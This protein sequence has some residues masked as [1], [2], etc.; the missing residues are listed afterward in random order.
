M[1]L[2][3]LLGSVFLQ[4]GCSAEAEQVFG[5]AM[6]AHPESLPAL[7]GRAA[8]LQSLARHSE[9][10]E[11]LDRAVENHPESATAWYNRGV[12]RMSTGQ[13][14][15]AEADFTGALALQPNSAKLLESRGAA[16]AFQGAQSANGAM[17]D[18]KSALGLDPRNPDSW[19]MLGRCF[20][21][22]GQ[23]GEAAACWRRALEIAPQHLQSLLDRGFLLSAQQQH[24]DALADFDRVISLWR[25][26]PAAWQGR[27]IAL[28]SLNHQQPAIDS[29]SE[30]LRISPSDTLSLFNRAVM[31]TAAKH[32]VDAAT[33]LEALLRLNP[34]YPLARGLL[35][36]ARLQLCDWRDL[37]QQ[38]RAIAEGLQRGFRVIHP[39]AHLLI[40]DSPAGQLA[41][42][43]LQ[44][45][46]AHP[47]A[48]APLYRG[49]KY[50]HDKIRIAYVSGD[51]FE[52]AVP[53][54]IVGVLEHHDRSRFEITAISYGSNDHSNMRRRLEAA[55]DRFVDVPDR[56]DSAIARRMREMEFDIAIDLKGHTGRARPG[57]F[58]SRPAPVQVNYLGYPGTMGAPYFD[59]LI[60]DRILIPP[61]HRPFYS[62]NIVYLPDCYQANDRARVIA[63]EPVSRATAG[64]PENAFVFC[65]F[66]GNQKILPD[67]F[68]MWMRI[69]AVA[70]NSV[71]WLMENNANAVAN[72]RTQ[73]Q[74]HGIAPDRLIFARPAPLDQHLARLRLADLVLDTLPY[75]AHTTASDALWA[76]VPVLT[77]IG[78][79]FAGRVAA[80]LLTAIG[81]PQMITR[82]PAEFEALALRLF[83]DR[84]L[85]DE[86][87]QEL[88]RN[89]TTAPLFDTER[90][91]RN[92]ERAYVEMW[93]RHRRGEPPA[94]L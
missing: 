17:E 66:N 24:T 72:L 56:P 52:H 1:E 11:L 22:L 37:D 44:T 61:G 47:P 36:N 18:L 63:P 19:H 23:T 94:D 81:L 43:R 21:L 88:A 59:Y 50:R 38:R 70:E 53:Y 10:G 40:S 13:Y 93:Q 26:H 48:A 46:E 30:A 41:C 15:A 78:N 73:A 39:F 42:A 7:Y 60:A 75:G 51:F 25:D 16:R 9:A 8:A 57:I 89:R 87:W 79:S 14:A 4:S 27:G 64:L 82:S 6:R 20:L 58:A 68:T 32:F 29:F 55:V 85:L 54:L 34:E 35:L 77:L 90:A 71:L 45:A 76:G 83:R 62:E 5:T 49:E 31:L 74:G 12:V 92:L 69:L 80:S 86:I 91:A 3:I 28:A 33:D 84:K 2:N 67:T 65:C